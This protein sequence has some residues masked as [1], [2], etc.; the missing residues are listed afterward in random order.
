M[1]ARRP[2][3]APCRARASGSSRR[4]SSCASTWPTPPP[5]RWS[6]PPTSR[7]PCCCGAASSTC[8]S[9]CWWPAAT[10]SGCTST[11]RASCGCARSATSCP[12]WARG[13]G[14]AVGSGW[15]TRPA[16]LAPQARP[17]WVVA[18]RHPPPARALSLAGDQPGQQDHA[19]HKLRG[20]QAQP[21]DRGAAQRGGQQ[22]QVEPERPQVGLPLL[23][24]RVRCGGTSSSPGCAMQTPRKL[25]R[26]WHGT[27]LPASA[28]EQALLLV[29]AA[30]GAGST[31]RWQGTGSSP[32][33]SALRT[34]WCSACWRS[35]PAAVPVLHGAPR[36]G[37]PQR[38]LRA[39]G[40]RHPHR[41]AQAV[42]RAGLKCTGSPGARDG[43]HLRQHGLR[44]GRS[45]QAW[46]GGCCALLRLRVPR[47]PLI[48][49]A[50]AGRGCWR[51][52][53]RPASRPTWRWTGA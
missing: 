43:L 42:R 20:Q 21:H 1:H 14:R 9:T 49:A 7:G 24:L 40:L 6:C 13:G 5:R 27:S 10:R 18:L 3:R 32:S 15:G 33:G 11:G 50:R 8:A 45:P 4:P 38:V 2:D 17:R 28:Q 48:E 12:R 39:A 19:H 31:W 34:W 36:G 25:F 30:R 37:P 53:T 41:R 52:T 23:W 46:H 47:W 16:Q 26:G 35:C 22:H 51:S 29:T 44:A